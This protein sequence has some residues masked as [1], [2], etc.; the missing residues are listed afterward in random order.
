MTSKEQAG[1]LA[2]RVERV[3]AD[4]LDSEISDAVLFAI[5]LAELLEV[6]KAADAWC[7]KERFDEWEGQ[8]LIVA[9]RQSIQAIRATGKVTL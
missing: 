8:K 7:N 3:Y 2:M 5:P 4:E 6:A 9:M 1:K